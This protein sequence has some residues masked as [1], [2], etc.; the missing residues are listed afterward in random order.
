MRRNL[1]ANFSTEGWTG[2]ESVH[3]QNKREQLLHF[4][5][6]EEDR[7]VRQWVDEYVS[8]LEQRIAR[9]KIAEERE[10]L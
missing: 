2:Y 10:D 6:S 8:E 4:R 5:G 1:I 3:L 7:N 9:A